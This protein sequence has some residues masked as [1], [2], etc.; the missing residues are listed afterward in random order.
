[1]ISVF[2]SFAFYLY[3]VYQVFISLRNPYTPVTYEYDPNLVLYTLIYN[4]KLVINDLIFCFKWQVPICFSSVRCFLHKE[5]GFVPSSND[6]IMLPRRK[7]LSVSEDEE[8]RWFQ[9]TSNWA[10]YNKGTATSVACCSDYCNTHF[11]H[12]PDKKI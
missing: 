10:N 6:S 7:K 4:L 1:M 8:L 9:Y 2:T 5:N 3:V 12:K 11:T